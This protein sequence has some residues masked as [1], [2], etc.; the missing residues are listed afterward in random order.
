MTIYTED[1]V[2]IIRTH[3]AQKIRQKLTWT[4]LCVFL[5]T[6]ASDKVYGKVNL[7]IPFGNVTYHNEAYTAY[8]NDQFSFAL[9]FLKQNNFKLEFKNNNSTL[10]QKTELSLKLKI[11]NLNQSTK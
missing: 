2:T 6:V 8:I 3:V 9:D 11:Q 1:N 10:G 4:T 5:Q 7:N